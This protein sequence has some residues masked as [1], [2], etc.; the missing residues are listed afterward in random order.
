MISTEF[1]LDQ[2]E[3]LRILLLGAHCDDIEIGC[4]GT[5]LNLI[6]K[7]ANLQIKWVVFA[8][9]E[10]RKKEAQRSAELFLEKVE[11][12]QIQILNFK[13]GFLPS[14]WSEVKMEFENLK[15]FSPDVIF[16]HYRKD[17]HQDHRTVNELTWNTFRDHLI[18]EYEIPK[19]DGDLGNPNLFVPL[20]KGLLKQKN[21]IIMGCFNSQMNK[22][23]L[24]HSLLE[25]MP[26]IRGVEC[27]SKS[28]YAEA[29]YT[30]KMIM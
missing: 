17:L 28:K 6:D 4:G 25:S 8:S 23:W 10:V 12:K 15:E 18:C 13:D 14:V 26:R 9:N 3:P 24:D 11:N 27:A 19:Y 21:D 16:T 2:N 1:S 29:F 7:Y 20:K 30:R 22:H 5:L